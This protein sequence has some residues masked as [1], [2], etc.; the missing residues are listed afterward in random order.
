[1]AMVTSV[2][3]VSPRWAR[4]TVCTTVGRLPPTS[5]IG[6]GTIGV[7][8]VGES[9]V[10]RSTVGPSQAGR[11]VGG[12]GLLV[13]VPRNPNGDTGFPGGGPRCGCGRNACPC[14]APPTPRPRP[15]PGVR[16]PADGAPQP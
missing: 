12:G 4:L 13:A 10:G 8:M 2:G 14:G 7:W 5:T 6:G 15:A 9:T 3:A 11:S 1:M 16:G